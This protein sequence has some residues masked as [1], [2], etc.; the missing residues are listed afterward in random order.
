MSEDEPN[1]N[2]QTLCDFTQISS[3]THTPAHFKPL[4]PPLK[5][6]D[7]RDPWLSDVGI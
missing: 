4:K 3:S 1:H 7:H 5:V 2:P 6:Y